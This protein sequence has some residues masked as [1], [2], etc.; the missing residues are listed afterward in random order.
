[1]ST[2]GPAEGAC[3]G[4]VDGDSVGEA[5]M[6]GILDGA[7]EGENVGIEPVGL[8]DGA[9]EGA[10]GKVGCVDGDELGDIV[11]DSVGVWVGASVNGISDSSPQSGR[12][13]SFQTSSK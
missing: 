13:S 4:G 3:V 7:A 12:G 2:V 9:A 5:V 8:V 11:T 10:G 6:T 1:M